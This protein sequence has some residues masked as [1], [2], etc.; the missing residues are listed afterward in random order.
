MQELINPIVF[1]FVFFVKV[2]DNLV[3][4][5]VICLGLCLTP[6]WSFFFFSFFSQDYE[7]APARSSLQ[8]CCYNIFNKILNKVTNVIIIP[9]L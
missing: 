7:L 3:Y 5:I 9:S 4:P 6:P 1:C 2:T 8:I